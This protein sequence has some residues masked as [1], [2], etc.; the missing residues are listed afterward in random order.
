MLIETEY[1]ASELKWTIFNNTRESQLYKMLSD[2]KMQEHAQ[3]SK[4][5]YAH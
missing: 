2:T 4:N 5:I 3:L 1:I